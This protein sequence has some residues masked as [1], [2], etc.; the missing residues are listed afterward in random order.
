[1]SILYKYH[2]SRGID[3]LPKRMEGVKVSILYKYHSSLQKEIA[4]K[5]Q[6]I[7]S[8]LYK[9]HSSLYL[10]NIMQDDWPCVDPL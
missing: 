7:V 4:L 5:E 3:S 9:Y 10:A 6:E 1:M 8:I 2:S